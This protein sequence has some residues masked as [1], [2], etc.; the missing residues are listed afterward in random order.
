MGIACP[1]AQKPAE[2][3]ANRTDQT[4]AQ[5]RI[6]NKRRGIDFLVRIPRLLQTVTDRGHVAHQS[7]G[8]VLKLAGIKSVSG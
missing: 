6:A 4:A 5:P 2:T 8:D 1:E 3:V 7:D